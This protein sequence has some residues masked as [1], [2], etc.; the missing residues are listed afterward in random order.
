HCFFKQPSGADPEDGWPV[1][2]A[3]TLVEHIMR[4]AEN[5]APGRQ[6]VAVHEARFNKWIN[7]I[8]ASS[9]PVDVVPQDY[10]RVAVGLGTN[11]N[12][13][14]ELA[15]THPSPS[16]AVWSFSASVERTPELSAEELYS[17]RWMFHGPQFQG[18]TEL[19]AIGDSHVRAVLTAP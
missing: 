7:V 13:V 2:P 3:T 5:A 8:P 12:A 18:V 6:A 15:A 4:F 1:V 9:V 10:D 11:A 16:P 14:I 17:Q 19:T